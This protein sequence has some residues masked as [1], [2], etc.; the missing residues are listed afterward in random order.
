MKGTLSCFLSR[1][2]ATRFLIAQW[3][4][5][6]VPYY[7]INHIYR[8]REPIKIIISSYFI[9]NLMCMMKVITSSLLLSLVLGLWAPANVNAQC[10]FVGGASHNGCGLPS[11]LSNFQGYYECSK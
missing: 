10:R 3:G 9:V 6:L 8:C 2:A 1:E 11:E 7:H 5:G 4:L